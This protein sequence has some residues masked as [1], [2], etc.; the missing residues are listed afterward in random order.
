MN[1]ERFREI[2][3]SK[4]AVT[5]SFPFDETALVFKVIDKMFAICSIDNFQSF[6]LK[7]D[8]EWAIE[9]REQYPEGIYGGYHLNKKHWNTV[10]ID[11]NVPEE[12][13]EKMIQHS[14]DLV[15]WKLTK[16]QKAELAEMK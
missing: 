5:E 16:K 3:L 4:K 1:I 8:P 12:L 13:M 10:R 14:Y 7:C 6:S 11:E 9:L 2:C 15:V